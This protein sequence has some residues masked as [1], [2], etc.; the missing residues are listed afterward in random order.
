MAFFFHFSFCYVWFVNGKMPPIHFA[1]N[2]DWH[3]WL[4][5][6]QRRCKNGKKW[7]DCSK[8]QWHIRRTVRWLELNPLS[9]SY[10]RHWPW[11]TWWQFLSN[12][13]V[14]I[15]MGIS[16]DF[17]E[18]LPTFPAVRTAHPSHVGG[19]PPV[20]VLSPWR[21]WTTAHHRPSIQ[22]HFLHQL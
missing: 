18:T 6:M 8:Y 21:Q 3:C 13:W 20:A 10:S 5:Q 22:T 1:S 19:H 12:C 16:D 9:H 15:K 17:P 14:L 7:L 4:L 11:L 2:S